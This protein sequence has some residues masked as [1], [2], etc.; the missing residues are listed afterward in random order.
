MSFFRRK[1]CSPSKEK[2]DTYVGS[3]QRFRIYR[4]MLSY[5]WGDT[6]VCASGKA[7]LRPVLTFL[8][9]FLVL[10]YAYFED[11]FLFLIYLL[12][13]NCSMLLGSCID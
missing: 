12:W 2:A 3:G 5:V 10:F 6:I 7:L 1:P 8:K 11:I 9:L 13:W 4:L